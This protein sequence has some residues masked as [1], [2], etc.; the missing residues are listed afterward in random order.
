MQYSIKNKFKQMCKQL[1]E[2]EI[3]SKKTEKLMFC[4]LKLVLGLRMLELQ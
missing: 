4:L 1:F 2:A 3:K